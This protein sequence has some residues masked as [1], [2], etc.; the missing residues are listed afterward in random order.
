MSFRPLNNTEIAALQNQGCFSSDWSKISVA[1][2]F[3]TDNIHQ[4]RFLGEVKLGGLNGEKS[5]LFN[6]KISHCEIGDD[7]LIDNVHLVENYQI[8]GWSY[9][10]ECGYNYCKWGLIF[11]EWC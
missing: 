1:D 2:Q 3:T 5:G 4:V 10:R 6:C 8:S 11:W 7:V 9:H